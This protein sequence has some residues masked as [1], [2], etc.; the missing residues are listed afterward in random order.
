MTRIAFIADI[1]GNLPAV[2]AVALDIAARGISRV[3][4]LGDHAS[5][6]LWPR[7]TI[8]FLMRQSWVSIAG[9]HDRQLVF[10][11]PACHGASDQYAFARLTNDQKQWLSALPQTISVNDGD[12]VCCHGT[13]TDDRTYLLET[14]ENGRLRLASPEEVNARLGDTTAQIVACAHSHIPR[15]VHA[16]RRIIAVNPGSV[17]LQAYLDDGPGP[18]VSETGSPF[19]RYALLESQGRDWR[20]TFVTVQYDHAAASRQAATNGRVD[21]AFSLRTG[22]ASS[23]GR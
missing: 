19:A 4:N 5:G 2:E 15:L 3:V 21:W 6:P 12:I 9:N 11:D 22:Y 1:H 14:A 13:P 16:Q 17:G 8:D 18:H 10:D 7:E 20:T 23:D